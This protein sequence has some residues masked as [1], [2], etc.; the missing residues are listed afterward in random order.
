MNLSNLVQRWQLIQAINADPALTAS[1]KIVAVSLMGF[2]NSKTGECFPSF[3][4]IAARCHVSKRTVATATYDLE[5]RKWV[6]IVRDEGGDR[7]SNRYFFAFDRIRVNVQEACDEG[8]AAEFHS[9]NFSPCLEG[10][11]AKSALSMVQNSSVHGA[12]SAPKLEEDNSFKGTQEPPSP[13]VDG[14]LPEIPVFDFDAWFEQEWWRQY[15]RKVEK[16]EAKKLTR[17][18]IEG[19]RRDGLKAT[20]Q[21]L[22]AGVIRYAAVMTGKD[23]RYVKHPTTWLNKGC[24]TDE[25]PEPGGFG[26][27]ASAST[28][29]VW[30]A[31]DAMPARNRRAG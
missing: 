1:A 23:P 31:I 17:A 24:W 20:P 26:G 22:L 15:P 25:H 4:K 21:E 3:E 9:E 12:K 29:A 5:R 14:A 19:R 2:V 16:I 18:I 11:G 8:M 27:R 6:K 28:N 7:E 13:N 30:S 10:H